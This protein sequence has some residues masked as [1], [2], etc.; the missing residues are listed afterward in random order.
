[1]KNHLRRGLVRVLELL[2]LILCVAT[3]LFFIVRSWRN[4][5]SSAE[6]ADGGAEAADLSAVTAI[7]CNNGSETL[8]FSL[9]EDGKWRWLDESFPVDQDAVGGLLEALTSFTPTVTAA[10]GETVDLAT[11]ELDFPTCAVSYTTAGGETTALQ[12]GKSAENGGAYV[13]YAD[14]DS[15]VYLA[16]ASL[17]AQIH[18]GLGDY[19]DVPAF[20]ALTTDT[21]QGLTLSVGEASAAY[22]V[23]EQKGESR[24]F[25]GGKDVTEDAAFSAALEEL[26]ALSF[27]ECLVWSPPKASRTIC[28]L[29]APKAKLEIAYH[30]AAGRD[31]TMTLS[32]GAERSSG[33]YFAAWSLNDAI[34]ALDS[35]AVADI[36][37]LA[38]T[39]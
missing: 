15:A 3:L 37:A 8:V 1:M 25:L 30:D 22:T 38:A 2:L 39:L 14:D 13:K 21:M 28:G 36:L 34:F 29:I 27:S 23:R 4:S 35:D 17:M 26:S 10:S 5:R 18:Q 31:C 12:F 9:G 20:P 32:I 24:W 6:E 33:G 7:S 16:G 11:Y 19:C